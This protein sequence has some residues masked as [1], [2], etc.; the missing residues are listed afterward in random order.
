[1][2]AAE[3]GSGV[4]A[5]NSLSPTRQVVLPQVKRVLNKIYIQYL[6]IIRI[7]RKNGD[8]LEKGGRQVFG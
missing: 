2:L 8:I 7:Y 5:V 4:D 6:F 3:P 1:M